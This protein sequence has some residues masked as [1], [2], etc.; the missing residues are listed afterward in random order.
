MARP[1]LYTSRGIAKR[2]GSCK[3]RGTHHARR[4]REGT[5][6]RLRAAKP[7]AQRAPG[8]L[9]QPASWVRLS[10]A[11]AGCP[12]GLRREAD[13]ARALSETSGLVAKGGATCSGSTGANLV[14]PALSSDAVRARCGSHGDEDKLRPCGGAAMRAAR[15]CF[16][17]AITE[18]TGDIEASVTPYASRL[19]DG[20][21]NA[22]YPPASVLRWK[23]GATQ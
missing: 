5:P 19:I 1:V 16:A 12:S 20:T 15:R 18:F 8:R 9:Y 21:A 3:V 14:S 23:Q 4:G 7:D 13:F 10:V 2:Q 17:L 22:W 6:P 11:A